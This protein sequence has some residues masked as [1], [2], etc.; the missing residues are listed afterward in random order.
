MATASPARSGTVLVSGS[1]FAANATV[2]FWAIDE[3]GRGAC[4]LQ[5]G[6][7]EAASAISSAPDTYTTSEYVGHITPPLAG[8]VAPAPC[9]LGDAATD[10]DGSF[11]DA[12]AVLNGNVALRR[13][14]HPGRGLGAAAATPGI[15]E[16]L[17]EGALA[18]VTI[19][20]AANA[21]KLIL[22]TSLPGGSYILD[23]AV[24]S[25]TVS[26]TATGYM[27][28]SAPARATT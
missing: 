3:S 26:F 6:S 5:P 7:H 1:G 17:N 11:T 20:S 10:G 14:A 21:G 23:Q 4:R 2:D 8:G 19:G 22:S 28:S 15:G 24:V 9:Y 12:G 25:Q 18:G 27:P 13:G 16:R